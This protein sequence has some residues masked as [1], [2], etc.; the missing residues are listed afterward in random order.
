MSK[1]NEQLGMR[2]LSVQL[3]RAEMTWYSAANNFFLSSVRAKLSYRIKGTDTE[4]NWS[5]GK[6]DCRQNTFSGRVHEKQKK[7]SLHH[8]AHDRM[9]VF[10]S[11]TWGS[12]KIFTF[13][14]YS[15]EKL[16]ELPRN[17]KTHLWNI[18]VLNTN[19][20]ILFFLKK[21]EICLFYIISSK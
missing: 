10:S 13:L 14:E 11:K 12:C 21:S 16:D 17:L 8:T 19:K 6:C 20:Q 3:S 1:H 4:Q 18:L 2:A 9:E 7:F 15:M 5:T